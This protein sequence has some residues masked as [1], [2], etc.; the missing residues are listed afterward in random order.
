MIVHAATIIFTHHRPADIT[1]ANFAIALRMDPGTLRWHFTDL[2][3][4]LHEVL[5][6]HLKSV[7]DAIAAIPRQAPHIYRARRAAYLRATRANAAGLHALFLRNYRAM[8]DDLREKLHAAH[9]AIGQLLHPQDPSLALT[10]L[11]SPHLT[12]HQIETLLAPPRRS[13][14]P[15]PRRRPVARHAKPQITQT[16]RAAHRARAGPQAAAA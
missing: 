16:A 4:L 14:R 6:R 1:F 12:A 5:S 10:L 15:I 13:H 3:A 7:V 9:H 2:D 11:D 8:P